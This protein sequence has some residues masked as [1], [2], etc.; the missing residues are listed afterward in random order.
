[1]SI[2]IKAQ[3]NSIEDLIIREHETSYKYV[4]EVLK[5]DD[6]S[7]TKYSLYI[8]CIKDAPIAKELLIKCVEKEEF[9]I[10]HI[11]IETRYNKI[12]LDKIT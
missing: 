8:F 2:V 4:V 11:E 6:G 9:D 5:Y 7:T 12:A 1:M 10:D 3:Y